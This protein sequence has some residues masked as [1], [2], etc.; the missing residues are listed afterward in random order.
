MT[1]RHEEIEELLISEAPR[2]SR[3]FRALVRRS[4]EMRAARGRRPSRE[5]KVRPPHL[6]RLVAAYGMS[7]ALLL[8]VA[9]VGLAGIGPF[10]A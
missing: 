10:A 4:L 6:F 5:R 7:G 3:R 2:P 9:A 1:D 8:A